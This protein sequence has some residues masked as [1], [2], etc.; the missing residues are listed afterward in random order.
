MLLVFVAVKK[1]KIIIQ[2]STKISNMWEI[3]NWGKEMIG[4]KKNIEE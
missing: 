4:K 1:K 2:K 3:L